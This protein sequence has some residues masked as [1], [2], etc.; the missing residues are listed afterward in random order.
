MMKSFAMG[1]LFALVNAVEIEREPL[2]SWAPTKCWPP[3]SSP[4][5]KDIVR[6]Y[7]VPNFGI[8]HDIKWTDASISNAEK[9]LKHKWT[10]KEK[11]DPVG[12]KDYTVPNFGMDRDIIDS[13]VNLKKV[14]GKLGNWNPTQD[15][16]GAYIVPIAY[17]NASYGYK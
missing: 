17:D 15:A 1:A 5:D 9:K 3:Q 6:D 16:D 7:T 4:C 12:P 8:D 11:G 2:L 13:N 14:E 10:P